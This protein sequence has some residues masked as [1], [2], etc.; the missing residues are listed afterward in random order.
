MSLLDLFGFSGMILL[1]SAF[2]LNQVN[3]FAND[4]VSYHVFNL[5]GAYI[6]TYYAFVLGN[7]PFIILEFVW[8]SFSLYQLTI[9]RSSNRKPA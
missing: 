3:Y 4:S 1:L 5:L 7:T 9:N 6:L 8:G 2:L